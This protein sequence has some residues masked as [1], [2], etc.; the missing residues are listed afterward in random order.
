MLTERAK[1]LT[2]AFITFVAFIWVEAWPRNQGSRL[3]FQLAQACTVSYPVSFF[4]EILH[5][6]PAS[7]STLSELK[8]SAFEAFGLIKFHQQF[9]EGT[10]KTTQ[11]SQL[12]RPFSLIFH[13]CAWQALKLH[14][15]LSLALETVLSPHRT[16]EGWVLGINLHALSHS[17]LFHPLILPCP[18]AAS[19][20]FRGLVRY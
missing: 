12:W 18:S 8:R 7:G 16:C 14:R 17:R 19:L 11:L 2:P 3:A 15:D 13:R 9:T 4:T 20:S 6:H 5:C 1:R 10:T